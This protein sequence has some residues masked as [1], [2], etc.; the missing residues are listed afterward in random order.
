MIVDPSPVAKTAGE[1]EAEVVTPA[2]SN[3]SG[4]PSVVPPS[5]VPPLMA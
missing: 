5:I 3:A 4:P 1:L 2:T